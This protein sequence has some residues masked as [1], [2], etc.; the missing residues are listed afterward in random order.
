MKVGSDV[1]PRLHRVLGPTHASQQARGGEFNRPILDF[2]VGVF[3][4]HMNHAVGVAPVELGHSSVQGD[5]LRQIVA[6]NPVV[7]K[8]GNRIY[9]KSRHDDE[10]A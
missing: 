1:I 8:Q 4:V 6:R 5:R 10:N 9:E 2:A 3:R 7:R